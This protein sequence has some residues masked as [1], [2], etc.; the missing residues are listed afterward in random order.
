MT[1]SGDYRVYLHHNTWPALAPE[2]ELEGDM[3][4]ERAAGLAF[5]APRM[6]LPTQHPRWT[7]RCSSVCF[8]MS[9]STL[10]LIARHAAYGS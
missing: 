8:H 4:I 5:C 1:D 9:S 6:H 7:S 3:V 10:L 2:L